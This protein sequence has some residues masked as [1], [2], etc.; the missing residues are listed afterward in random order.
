MVSPVVTWDGL[1]WIHSSDHACGCAAAGE[2]CSC[3]DESHCCGCGAL[4]P[5]GAPYWIE[6]EQIGAET[7][8][9]CGPLP[10]SMLISENDS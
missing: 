5:A 4:I 9:D 8:E 2:E 6:C 1:E 7:C 10:E 3:E